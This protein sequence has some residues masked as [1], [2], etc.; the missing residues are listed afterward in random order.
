MELAAGAGIDPDRIAVGGT[1]A[2]AGLATIVA[3]R[4]H[5]EGISLRAQALVA[6]MLDDRTVL[7]ADHGGRGRFVWTPAAN[8]FAWTAYL[9][10]QPGA[11]DAPEY[12]VA[13]RRKD[14]TG[15]PP[16]W[17]GVG[18]IDL[19]HDEDVKYA[20]QLEASGV[21]CELVV[22]PGMYHCAETFAL[23]APSI[24]AFRRSMVEHLRTY[25]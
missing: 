7:R 1:S 17:M 14:L 21:P 4:C 10:H 22:V 19:F 3:Q 20:E 12:A 8:R 24:K 16:A 18:D 11:A 23:K 5:D 13:A 2:G 25:L 9:G 15:L 6:P